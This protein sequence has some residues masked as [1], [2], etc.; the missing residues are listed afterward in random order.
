MKNPKFIKSLI[1]IVFIAILVLTGVW[2]ITKPKAVVLQGR[3][4]A[5]EI[6]LAAKIP[7]RINSFE[8]K[9]G[10][11]VTK[12]QLLATLFSPEIMAK[13]QQALALRDAAKAQK[14]KVENGARVEEIRA[15]KSVYEKA[16]AAV[17]VLIKTYIR[18][19]NLFKDGVISEQQRDEFFAKKEVALKDQEAAL[20][21]YQMAMKGA[22]NE[23]I[24]AA[25][26]LLKQ[27]NGALNEL[28]GYK[29]ERNIISPID[30]EI[31]NFL[32]EEG[33]LIGA[34]YPVVH[35]VD[36][37]N[38]YAILNIKETSLFNFKKE[39]I[40]EATIPALKH[41]KVKFKIYYVAALGD[42][43][44][45]NATKA[46]GGFDVRTFEIKAAPVSKEVELRPGMSILIDYSQFNE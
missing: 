23:D 3:I 24:D 16:T 40:F 13:E 9:E 30:A 31:L 33:E 15:A 18:M 4:E 17:N 43:A 27:A 36:L 8:V 35:L 38:S 25:T 26:A 7:T 46:T 10:E 2:F 29:N 45:W 11:H 39:G 42:Y 34:G 22:R 37:A 44:T 41:K 6:Y 12:G 21:M 28:E 32:P 1:S 5:K 20:S 14:S 19:E